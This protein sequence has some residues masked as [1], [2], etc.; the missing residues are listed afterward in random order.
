MAKEQTLKQSAIQAGVQYV[1]WLKANRLK[2]STERRRAFIA[3]WSIR[4]TTPV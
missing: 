1:A 4:E 2:D 3:G